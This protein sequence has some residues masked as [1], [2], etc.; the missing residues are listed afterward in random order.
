MARVKGK[1]TRPELLVRSL[2]HRM[3]Y[4]FRLH[5]KSLP[6]TPDLVFPSRMKIIFVNGCFWHWHHRCREFRASQSRVAFW[7]AKLTKNR[8][9]DIRNK[10]SLRKL[11]WDVLTIWECQ[12]RDSEELTKRIETFMEGNVTS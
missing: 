3:G 5:R 8:E 11:G 10:K 7:E 2:V 9:R 1:D 6:G 12:T 4:R